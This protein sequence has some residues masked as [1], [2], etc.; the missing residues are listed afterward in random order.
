MSISLNFLAN[1][2][3]TVAQ[4]FGSGSFPVD[5]NPRGDLCVAQAL[6]ERSELVR[7]GASYGAQIKEA[8]AFTALITVPTT[9]AELA[10]QNGE[11]AGGKTYI[12]DRVW[13]KNVT[14]TAAANYLTILAQVIAA[15]TALVADSA[16]KTIQS[17]SGKP[18]YGGKAQLAV[19]SS[20]VGALSDKWFTLGAAGIS[21]PT[22]T[23]IAAAYEVLCYGRYLI[24]P[25]GAF[26]LNAQEAVSG[27]TGI[28]GVEFHEVQLVLG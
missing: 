6:P 23:S 12:I 22:S 8:N 15:G 4:L 16:N 24:P 9:L 21:Q 13:Y 1:V 26:A 14:T 20:S 5:Q 25:G 18:N 7:L 27:G 28:L 19:H 10:L 11:A 17:L 3:Q 2:R